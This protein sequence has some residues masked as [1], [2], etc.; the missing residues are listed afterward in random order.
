LLILGY[1]AMVAAIRIWTEWTA[2]IP[3]VLC[4]VFLLPV[5]GPLIIC[6]VAGVNADFR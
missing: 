1:I 5:A 2:F 4:S 3:G 6:G